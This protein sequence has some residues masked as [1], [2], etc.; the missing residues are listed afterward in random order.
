MHALFGDQEALSKFAQAAEL[1]EAARLL[2]PAV[3]V[4]KCA[5]LQH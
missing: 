5:D 1:A 2:R 4:S 3:Q